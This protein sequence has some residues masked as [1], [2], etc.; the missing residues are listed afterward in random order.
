[1]AGFRFLSLEPLLGPVDLVSWF[2]NV[3]WSRF[4]TPMRINDFEQEI[5][6]VIVGGESGP[7]AR[8]CNVKWIRSIVQQC[9]AASVPVFVKQLGAKPSV[10]H[11]L[12]STPDERWQ[13]AL[14]GRDGEGR[15]VPNDSKGGDINE[16]PLDLRVREM[17]ELA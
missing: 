8:P 1:M 9:E 3:A 15:P 13:S 12:I 16:F 7:G 5:H 10:D 4:G 17:P 6:W 14:P 2:D 11:P